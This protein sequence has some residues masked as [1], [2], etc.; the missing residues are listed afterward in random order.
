VAHLSQTGELSRF[1]T[2][3]SR[4]EEIDPETKAVFAEVAQDQT[5]LSALDDYVHGTRQR[6]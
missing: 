2:E 5:F 1:L 6:H 3:L 4:S